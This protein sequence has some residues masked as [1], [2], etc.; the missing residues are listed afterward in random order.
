[1][2]ACELVYFLLDP[3]AI[4]SHDDAAHHLQND[5]AGFDFF[6]VNDQGKTYHHGLYSTVQ[7]GRTEARPT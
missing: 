7:I 4:R 1:M 6:F 2:L 5:N 3:R